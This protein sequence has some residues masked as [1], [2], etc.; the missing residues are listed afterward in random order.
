MNME[1]RIL[2]IEDKLEWRQNLAR[3][4]STDI[5]VQ[6][7][8]ATVKDAADKIRRYHYDVVLLDLSMDDADS[9]NRETQPIQDYLSTKPDGTAYFVVSGTA[10]REE[11]RDAAFNSGAAFVFFKTDLNL[12]HAIPEKVAAAI[13]DAAYRRGQTLITARKKLLPD[14]FLEHEIFVALDIGAEDLYSIFNALCRVVAPIASHSH[15]LT[16]VVRNGL[17]MA[18]F[19]SRRHGTAVSVVLTQDKVQSDIAKAALAQWLGFSTRGNVLL[20]TELHRVRMLAFEE[21]TITDEHFDLPVIDVL[22]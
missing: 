22:P 15:R 13:Q 19:W 2:T 3:W 21:P 5:A 14:Q 1:S 20:D 18:L 10:E 17:V 16:C 9:R 6:D 11:T 4:I 8:V 7:S 12:H